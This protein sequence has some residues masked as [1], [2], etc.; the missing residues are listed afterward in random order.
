MGGD[1]VSGGGDGGRPDAL[2]VK[3]GGCP[4]AGIQVTSGP[5]G[6]CCSVNTPKRKVAPRR[7][8]PSRQAVVAAKG[9]RAKSKPLAIHAGGIGGISAA[10]RYTMP[11]LVSDMADKPLEEVADGSTREGAG[12]NPTR[13]EPAEKPPA[14]Q[15]SL[16]GSLVDEQEAS[17][18]D[19]SGAAGGVSSKVKI[20]VH[21]TT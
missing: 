20:F 9:K 3:S 14:D 7:M 13:Q 5:S 19:D 16:A 10:N 12:N 2:G 15:P 8:L 1:A 4:G 21:A 6:T 11:E 18:F 17:S